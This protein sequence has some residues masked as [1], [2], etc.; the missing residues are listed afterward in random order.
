MLGERALDILGIDRLTRRDRQADHVGAVGL[1]DLRPALTERAHDAEQ[2]LLA[3]AEQIRDRGFE[4]T[5]AT[6]G[7][8][9]DVVV[10]AQRPAQPADNVVEHR[11]E[12]RAAVVDHGTA[13]GADHASGERGR[14]GNAELWFTHGPKSTEGRDGSR[15]GREGA[16]GYVRVRLGVLVARRAY[17]YLCY[18][19]HYV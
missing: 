4:A 15:P 5:G 12:L 6:A 3:G 19:Y 10:G 11:G 1:T 2:G 9:K 18:T 13:R 8:E 14:T 7:V 17:T 16:W